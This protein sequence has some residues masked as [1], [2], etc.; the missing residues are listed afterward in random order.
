MLQVDSSAR[1]PAH[2][3]SQEFTRERELTKVNIVQLNSV[4]SSVDLLAI[5]DDTEQTP[6]M[7]QNHEVMET[8][9]DNYTP[10]LPSHLIEVSLYSMVEKEDVDIT[11]C[12][13]GR[14]RAGR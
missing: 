9:G 1:P 12:K 8:E 3:L 11:E 14:Q 5:S 10:I 2:I 4:N 6:S 7:P 13:S